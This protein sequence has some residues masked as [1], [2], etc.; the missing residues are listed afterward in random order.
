[1]FEED[2]TIVMD[3]AC[4]VGLVS[5]ELIAHAK[6]IVGVDI[7]Q[8]MVDEYNRRTVNQGLS[9]EEMHAVR[10]DILDLDSNEIQSM[11]G[12][13]D[14]IVCSAAYHHLDDITATTRALIKFLK[15]GGSL[16]VLD[17]LKDENISVD[18]VFPEHEALDIVAHRGGFAREQ[19]KGAFDTAGFS[20]FVFEDGIKAKKKGYPV[21]LF[22]AR[23]IK[24]CL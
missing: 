15:P 20:S 13:F 1:M 5:R 19:I 8:K 3:F 22:I 16:L 11:Q 23:G 21:T 24:S 4:G 10:A 12:S 18:E 6:S 17:L 14:V 2:E 7:S 9:M